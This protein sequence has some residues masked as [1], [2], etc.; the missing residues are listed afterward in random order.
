MWH[1]CGMNLAAAITWSASRAT[2]PPRPLWASAQRCW[3]DGAAQDVRLQ[4][5]AA[6]ALAPSVAI[7]SSDF[8]TGGPGRDV[9]ARC[10]ES[11]ASCSYDVA[12]VGERTQGIALVVVQE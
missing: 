5:R 2:S 7:A 3:V 6:P 12:I 9:L 10:L 8:F 4:P 11:R 1:E